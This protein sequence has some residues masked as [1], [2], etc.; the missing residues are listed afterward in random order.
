MN[1]IFKVRI[2]Q[3]TRFI[4]PLPALLSVLLSACKTPSGAQQVVA[5]PVEEIVAT[6]EDEVRELPSKRIAWS[7]YWKLCWH[8]PGAKAY[9]LQTLTSEGISPKRAAKAIAV[10]VSKLRRVKTTNP[11]DFSTARRYCRCKQVSLPIE[12]ER[13]LTTTL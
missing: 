11:K 13:Y 8:Y 6:L 9:E 7:T 3:S 2:L 5:P 1:V 10:F 4:L 12:C